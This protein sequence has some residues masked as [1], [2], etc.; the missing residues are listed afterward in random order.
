MEAA[1]GEDHVL[2][3]VRPAAAL[4]ATPGIASMLAARWGGSPPSIA[5][6]LPPSGMID[7][8]DERIAPEPGGSGNGG[9]PAPPCAPHPGSSGSAPHAPWPGA[10]PTIPWMLAR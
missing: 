6:A 1:P 10:P 7:G 5:A 2:Q 4:G 3:V 9:I 8:H